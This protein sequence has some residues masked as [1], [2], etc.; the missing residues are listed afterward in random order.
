MKNKSLDSIDGAVSTLMALAMYARHNFDAVSA[1]M[2]N[3]NNME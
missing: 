2:E 3:I 1:L